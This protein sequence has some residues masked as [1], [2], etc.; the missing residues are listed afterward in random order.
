M[1]DQYNGG[2]GLYLFL[3]KEI[4]GHQLTD[5]V[6][7][8]TSFAK[9]TLKEWNGLLLGIDINCHLFKRG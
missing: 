7:Q 2:G 3:K 4:T 1:F 8:F 6:C 5:S 9:E